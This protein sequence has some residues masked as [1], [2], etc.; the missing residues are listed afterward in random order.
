MWQR[1]FPLQAD[2][3]YTGSIIAKWVFVL[4]T[5]MT[6]VRSGI[7]MF[8]ADGGAESIATIPLNTFSANAAAAVILIM[9]LWGLS[10]IIMGIL[11]LI[12]LWRYQSLIPLMYVFIIVE[13]AMRIFLMHIKPV[14]V[15]G[16]A[17]GH[18][19]NYV[20]V[21]LAIIMLIL[22]LLSKYKQKNLEN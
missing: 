11:Y 18:V 2:N 21:P 4:I 16:T 17:P 6:L 10:Q 1:L 8:A 3:N 7:H 20:M 15:T 12:V 13:Y 14:H 9:A 5:L 19:G 22:S